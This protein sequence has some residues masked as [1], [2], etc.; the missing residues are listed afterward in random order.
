LQIEP[1]EP[2][3][4][5]AVGANGLDLFEHPNHVRDALRRVRNGGNK[6][7]VVKEHGGL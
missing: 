6:G 3:Q 4:A 7:R 5:V 1:V 2:L